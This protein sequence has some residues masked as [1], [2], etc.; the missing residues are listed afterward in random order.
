MLSMRR[1]DTGEAARD[2]GSAL[3]LDE[4]DSYA[5]FGLGDLYT[6]AGRRGEALIQYRAGLAKDPNNPVG[7]AAVQ[8]LLQ[9]MNAARPQPSP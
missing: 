1:G 3:D 2:F 4:S 6:L 5:H 7:L 9:Q 8:R